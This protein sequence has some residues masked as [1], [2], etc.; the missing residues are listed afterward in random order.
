MLLIY[1]QYLTTYIFVCYWRGTNNSKQFQPEPQLSDVDSPLLNDYC[2]SPDNLTY[3]YILLYILLDLHLLHPLT[4]KCNNFQTATNCIILFLHILILS[5][6]CQL[7]KSM[8]WDMLF[9]GIINSGEIIG[10]KILLFSR[11]QIPY[12]SCI[13]INRT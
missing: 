6:W 1:L 11:G 5:L 2:A 7:H 12:G 8:L 10:A 4:K 9:T 3:I 13:V